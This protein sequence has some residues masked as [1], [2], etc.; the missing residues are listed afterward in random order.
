MITFKQFLQEEA[1]RPWA[2]NVIEQTGD[3][4][5]MLRVLDSLVPDWKKSIFTDDGM[6]WRGFTELPAKAGA[7]VSIDTRGSWRTS[8]DTNNIYQVMMDA[9]VN[10][11]DF[12]SRSESIIVTSNIT[13]ARRYGNGSSDHI[14]AI[15]PIN[16]KHL[17]CSAKDDF[18]DTSI[19]PFA[20]DIHAFTRYLGYVNVHHSGAYWRNAVDTAEQL[21]RSFDNFKNLEHFIFIWHSSSSWTPTYKKHSS[22]SWTP[23]YKGTELT[24]TQLDQVTY[25]RSGYEEVLDILTDEM[26]KGKFEMTE[27]MRIAYKELSTKKQSEWVQALSDLIMTPERLQLKHVAPYKSFP[28]DKEMWF[29]GRC[30]AV[31]NLQFRDMLRRLRDRGELGQT[32][33]EI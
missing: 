8:K 33:L 30:L 18:I 32:K 21:Q 27:G 28:S 6:L 25:R 4:D 11:Q 1:K 12:D 23:T 5:A 13:A 22:S 20:T 10:M 16:V 15:F 31:P 17:V 2:V 14:Y 26:R 29:T 19:M 7:T 3:A 9:S 24:E